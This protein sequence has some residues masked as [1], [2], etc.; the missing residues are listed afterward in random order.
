MKATIKYKVLF[1][2]GKKG[3]IKVDYECPDFEHIDKEPIIIGTEVITT[4]ISVEQQIDEWVASFDKTDLMY[5]ND[6]MIIFNWDIVSAKPKDVNKNIIVK[7]RI[8]TQ[9]EMVGLFI[10]HANMTEDLK[11]EFIAVYSNLKSTIKNLKFDKQI[12]ITFKSLNIAMMASKEAYRS[13]IEILKNG[14]SVYEKQISYGKT[15][16]IKIQNQEKR[17]IVK[18]K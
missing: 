8:L 1:C 13:Q 16:Y 3:T 2:S 12:D 6:I 7:Q 18:K 17:G 4:D 14:L 5:S 15:N 10:K 9:S 11:T